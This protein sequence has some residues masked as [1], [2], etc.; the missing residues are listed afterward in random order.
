MGALEG[1]AHEGALEEQALE[2]VLGS[3]TE[4]AG[5]Q[6]SRTGPVWLRRAGRDQ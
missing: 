1:R 2:V 4:P 5:A 3:R 6:E